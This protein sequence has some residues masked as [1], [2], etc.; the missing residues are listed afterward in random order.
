M[1]LSEFEL[2]AKYFSG[3]GDSSDVAVSVGDD[4]AI[5]DVLAN[6]RM[7]LSVDTVVESVHFLPDITPEDL[8]W[9]AVA[10]AASDLAA[11]GARPLGMTLALTLPEADESWLAAFSAGLRNVS[12]ALS[13]PLIGGDTTRGFLTIAVHV[14]GAVPRDRGLLRSGAHVGDQVLVSG[15]LGDG[16]GAL[17]MMTGNWDVNPSYRDDLKARFLK[18]QPK[19]VLGQR[20]LGVATSAIDVSDGLLADA[21]HICR[22]S[23]VGM[24]LNIQDLPLSPALKSH[25]DNAQ[26]LQWALSG[27]D[28]YE[29]CF[30]LPAGVATPE[31]CTV[32]G[33]V[34]VGDSVICEGV[35]SAKRGYQHF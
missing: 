17:A 31:G 21:G 27:G 5:M 26:A 3:I 9:R 30:T 33:E 19:I 7:V 28:D 6:E 35:D 13:L 11:M 8:A 20:L 1:A 10:V 18:P 34:I 22:A 14:M 15:V 29:L 2:I 4:C 16:A 23:G 12:E 25:S 32:I 24:S